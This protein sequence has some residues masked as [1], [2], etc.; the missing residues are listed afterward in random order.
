MS[1]DI[2]LISDTHFGHKGI[3]GF[4]NA[5]GSPARTFSSVEEMNETMVE[6]WNSVVKDG[7]IVYHLGDVMFGPKSDFE[8]LWNRLNGRKRLCWGNHDDCKYIVEKRFFQKTMLWRMFPEFGIICTHVPIHK[9]QLV[10]YRHKPAD[11]QKYYRNV[12]GH[13]HNTD[14]PSDLHM[15]VCVEKIN[16]TPINIEDVRYEY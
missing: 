1:R 4:K 16:Y 13:I 14:S 5:D 9:S 15:N 8:E 7:D 11:G 6:N 10:N 3:L 12:H 2:W